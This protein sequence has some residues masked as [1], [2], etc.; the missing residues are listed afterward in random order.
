MQRRDRWASSHDGTAPRL[1]DR[2]GQRATGGLV[3]W[4]AAAPCRM[5]LD[6]TDARAQ[7]LHGSGRLHLRDLPASTEG[8]AGDP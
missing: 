2:E 1:T 4:G 5:G 3:T 6:A 8:D 7:R